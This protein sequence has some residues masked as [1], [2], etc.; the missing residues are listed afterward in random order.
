[1]KGFKYAIVFLE[2]AHDDGAEIDLGD[3]VLSFE[4][5]L[6]DLVEASEISHWK[7]WLGTL[8]WESL[9][10]NRRVIST[11]IA[12]ARPDVSD[13]DNQTAVDRAV[14]ASSTFALVRNR[15]ASGDRRALHGRA[16][17]GNPRGQL[18]NISGF[19][20]LDSPLRPFYTTRGFYW[21]A[22]KPFGPP[23]PI[24]EWRE[25]HDIVRTGLPP[26]LNVAL[27][28][29]NEALLRKG[30]EF[31][32]PEFVRAA[33]CVLALTRKEGRTA[34]AQKA[35]RI[36]PEIAQ[37]PVL[38]GM[39]VN[40][41]LIELYARRSDCVHGRIP[42]DDLT[43]QGEA[44]TD[45]AARLEY[46]SEHVARSAVITALRHPQHSTIFASRAALEKAWQDGAFP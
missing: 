46:V 17:D 33:D 18:G 28:S 45:R 6:R 14:Q 4:A 30:L 36:A 20:W 23:K 27:I 12:T 7:K 3:G 16:M 35:L 11:R 22:Q 34:F 40:A 21:D 29:F 13:L 31:R 32:I 1:M 44:G 24:Q 38:A 19:V 37:S 5:P 43:A 26:L 2:S 10:K 8:A 15:N 9:E 41:F 39:D 42:F 25:L